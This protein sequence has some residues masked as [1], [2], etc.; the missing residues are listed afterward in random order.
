ME[1]MSS[2]VD[3]LKFE[4]LL[5]QIAIFKMNISLSPQILHSHLLN[6]KIF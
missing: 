1:N 5:K 4:N 2:C 6:Y 3:R